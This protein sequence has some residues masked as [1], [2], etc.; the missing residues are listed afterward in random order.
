MKEPYIDIQDLR[1]RLDRWYGGDADPALTREITE[2]MRQC[3]DLP[4]DLLPDREMF[5]AIDSAA[6]TPMEMPE[7]YSDRIDAALAEE[8]QCSIP[9]AVQAGLRRG[10]R[11]RYAAAAAVAALLVVF[12]GMHFRIMELDDSQDRMASASATSA[13]NAVKPLM[14]EDTIRTVLA[15]INP[16]ARTESHGADKPTGRSGVRNVNNVS[17]ATSDDLSADSGNESVNAYGVADR[18]SMRHSED[19]F[20]EYIAANY[21]VVKSDVEASAIISGIFAS[22]DTRLTEV[23]CDVDDIKAEYNVRVSGMQGI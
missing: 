1:D 16:L 18:D 11:W 13:T 17:I 14:A 23:S 22:V 15:A 2:I 4:E 20:A 19:E 9:K 8:M 21:R 12:A 3:A 5:L 10:W 6:S 7:E